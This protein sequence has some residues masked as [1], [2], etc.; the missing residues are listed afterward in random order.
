MDDNSQETAMPPTLL[1]PPV[2]IVGGGL[3]G[4]SAAK[5][6]R[7]EGFDGRVVLLASEDEVPYV[8]PPLSKEFLAGTAE[9]KDTRVEPESWYAGHEVELLRGRS[10]VAI[11]VSEHDLTLDDHSHLAYDRALI[12]TGAS[13]RRLPPESFPDFTGVHYLRTLASS[14]TL[15]EALRV[16][17]RRVVVV[18]AGWIG[19][20]VA[21]AAR[22]YGNEVTVLGR[23]DVPLVAAIGP[24]LGGYVAQVQRRNGV[25]LRM[26]VE[27]AGFTGTHNGLH[28]GALHAPHAAHGSVTGVL[29]R[30]GEEV[31]ADIVVVGIG[32]APNTGLARGVGLVEDDGIVVDA[33]LSAGVDVWAAG[34]VARAFHPVLG[35]H[36]RIEH[37]A[38]AEH[39]GAAAARSLLGQLVSYD[40]VPYFYT[41][42]FD[43]SMEF[44]GYGPLMSQA[45]VVYRGDRDSGEFIAFWVLP[46]GA[47]GPGASLTGRTTAGTPA[48][49]GARGRVVAGMNV[50]VWDVNPAI[51]AL[52]AS[53]RSVDVGLL[54]DPGT[55]L[56]DLSQASTG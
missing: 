38:N 47:P 12:A 6:L 32:A 9:R 41:D 49:A 14:E 42:Q 13:P 54:S 3:A 43:F 35:Q 29:L 4:A 31:P 23:E 48:S 20:E 44:S 17:G 5:T 30:A 18:G 21:A 50:N 46:D 51:E 39:Q 40:R 1:P 26:G 16:G 22:G 36:L 53:G 7:S 10:A 27:V 24:E 8:R 34:D 2:V 56:T 55:A 11:D 19:L 52:I 45:Q 25:D 28:L 33:S 15:R 37:W